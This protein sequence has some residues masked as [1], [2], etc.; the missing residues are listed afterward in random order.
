MSNKNDMCCD[1]KF[2]NKSKFNATVNKSDVRIRCF[3][4]G[5][6]NHT[7]NE[8]YHKNKGLKCFRCNQF[9]HKSSQCVFNKPDVKNE[10]VN[11]VVHEVI[12]EINSSTE[13]RK[14]VKI[15]DYDFDALIATGSTITLVQEFIVLLEDRR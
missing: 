10:V 9:G 5:L 8:C 13:M 6:F 14:T 2:Q 4:C 15:N 3:N 7:S 1:N 12:N 11:E